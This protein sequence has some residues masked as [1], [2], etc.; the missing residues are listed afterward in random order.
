MAVMMVVLYLNSFGNDGRGGA[1][2]GR[3]LGLGSVSPK[4]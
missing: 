3:A 1:G 4:R 2:Q